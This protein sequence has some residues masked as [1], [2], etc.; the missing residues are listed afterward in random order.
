MDM[1]IEFEA[2][3]SAL[4]AKKYTRIVNQHNGIY[5]VWTLNNVKAEIK[6]HKQKKIVTYVAG[7][8][9]NSEK[10]DILATELETTGFTVTRNAQ[11]LLVDLMDD[12][13]EGF[14]TFISYIENIDSIAQRQ[15]SNRFY[16][17]E[18]NDNV[19]M[20]MA[21]HLHTD[22]VYKTP[23]SPYSRLY[24]VAD[25]VDSMIYVGHSVDGR[26]A[27]KV[28][29]P[30]WR[31]HTNPCDWIVATGFKMYS[32]GKTIPEVAEMIKR[33]LKIAIISKKEQELLDY[34][35]GLKTT[36]PLGFEDGHDPLSRLFYAGIVLEN[37]G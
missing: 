4:E 19:Y 10:L 3:K 12:V 8:G 25:A 17:A 11:H 23:G 27:E 18:Y 21:T 36:M 28:G 13:L 9:L 1:P 34:E 31:E 16:Q 6:A 35:L 37:N 22:W 2:F 5:A 33:N 30:V 32:V 14:L 24:G 7:Q 20:S 15:R 26:Q 29:G